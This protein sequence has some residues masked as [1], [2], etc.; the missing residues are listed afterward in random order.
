MEDILTAARSWRPCGD[1][2]LSCRSLSWED[3]ERFHKT[4]ELPPVHRRTNRRRKA[5]D[6]PV[7]G[8]AEQR[9]PARLP[10]V[11]DGERGLDDEVERP[12]T[13]DRL[14]DEL[15]R[16]GSPTPSNLVVFRDN[17]PILDGMEEADLI[18]RAKAGHGPSKEWLLKRFHRTILKI[19]RKSVS[20]PRLKI[21]SSPYFGDLVAAGAVGFLEALHRFNPGRNNRLY[22]YAKHY[23]E[24]A[25][26]EEAKSFWQNGITGETRIDRRIYNRPYDKPEWIAF[27]IKKPGVLWSPK[28]A[29]ELLADPKAQK[30][31]D[32][33]AVAQEAM[34]ERR[35]RQAFSSTIESGYSEDYDPEWSG[36]ARV[37]PA[38][39]DREVREC[40]GGG[41]KVTDADYAYIRKHRPQ[42]EASGVRWPISRKQYAEDQARAYRFDTAAYVQQRLSRRLINIG[43]NLGVLRECFGVDENPRRNGGRKIPKSRFKI[44]SGEGGVTPLPLHEYLKKNPTPEAHINK[45]PESIR[46]N[47]PS[48]GV[49]EYLAAQAEVRNIQRFAHME[50]RQ[51]ALWLVR[52]QER[53]EE[54]RKIFSETTHWLYGNQHHRFHLVEIG[55]A[56]KA[57]RNRRKLLK[58]P[59]RRS[60]IRAWRSYE[61]IAAVAA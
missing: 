29:A 20:D 43:R 58:K 45:V 7:M 54:D 50:R 48:L 53:I 46:G 18:R 17:G 1:G 34:T 10:D 49:V 32:K 27:A 35:K 8:V 57:K 61:P 37:E 13:F 19:A 14:I 4:G 11:L 12:E 52:R 55:Q 38:C 15:P 36:Q 3:L 41:G 33:I 42:V 16:R 26:R 2:E 59:R 21:D 22:A 56:E 47:A 30:L 24:K 5:V 44:R 51:Y 9:R 31:I 28:A 23:I 39:W 25:I 6:R 60:R 40:D